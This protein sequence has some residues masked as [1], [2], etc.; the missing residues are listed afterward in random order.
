[1][2]M[3][4]ESI[5]GQCTGQ[6]AWDCVEMLSDALVVQRVRDGEIDLFELIMRRYNQ[7][8][9]RIARSILCD[10]DEAADVVQETYVSAYEHLGDFE[11]RSKFSTWLAKIAVYDACARRRKSLRRK[12]YGSETL[13]LQP[14][15]SHSPYHNPQVGASNNELGQVLADVVDQL[16]DELRSVFTLR[17]VEGLDT[18]ETAECLSLSTANVKTRLHRARQELRTRVDAKIGEDIRKLYQFD[19]QRCDRI[20]DNVMKRLHQLSNDARPK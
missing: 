14:M 16:P 20:V 11:G 2:Q 8:L 18:L 12:L 19:G 4:N 5:D 13:D 17:V 1:M 15:N 6:S 10:D 7:R 9:F 3:R